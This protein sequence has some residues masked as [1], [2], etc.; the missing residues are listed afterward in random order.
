M[1]KLRKKPHVISDLN[2]INTEL[3][4]LKELADRELASIYGLTGMI[5][6]PHLD[7][8]MQVCIKKA[9]ILACLKKQ[10]ILPLSEVELI[11]AALDSIHK[12][13]KNNAIVEY[14][15]NNYQRR[16]SPLKLSKSGKSVQKWAKYWLL[17]LSDEKIDPDWDSQVREIWPTYFLIRTVDL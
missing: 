3:I 12:R 7:A 1:P 10:K 5:Y 15:G 17:Q 16:F 14:K 11:S 9:E 4:P 13:V 6:T 2:D 8:Y